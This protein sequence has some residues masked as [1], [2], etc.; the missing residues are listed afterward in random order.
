MDD[1]PMMI[2]VSVSLYAACENKPKAKLNLPLAGLLIFLN[3]LT[4]YSEYAW[5]LS[6]IPKEK[7]SDEI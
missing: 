5:R 6:A 7:V 2:E 4:I 3:T 1:I